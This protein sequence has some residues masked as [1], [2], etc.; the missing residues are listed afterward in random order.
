MDATT[1]GDLEDD[2]DMLD[3]HGGKKKS[4]AILDEL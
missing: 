3:G 4:N 1:L 2:E